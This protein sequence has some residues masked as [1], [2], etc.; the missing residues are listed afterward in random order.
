MNDFWLF[1]LTGVTI[2]CFL[3]LLLS[4]WC[5]SSR[6]KSCHENLWYF[7]LKKTDKPVR[8]LV[9][10]WRCLPWHH[11]GNLSTAAHIFEIS[12]LCTL[13]WSKSRAQPMKERSPC[14][15]GAISNICLKSHPRCKPPEPMFPSNLCFLSCKRTLIVCPVC[16]SVWIILQMSWCQ[17][18]LG[19][20][21]YQN[22]LLMISQP[23]V[24]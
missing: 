6:L 11:H 5:L 3:L 1:L 20:L 8:K 10:Q 19:F 4:D 7:N 17:N 13:T 12:R 9:C 18:K 24:D 14:W 21:L 16:A 15:P 23:I 22:C 2:L